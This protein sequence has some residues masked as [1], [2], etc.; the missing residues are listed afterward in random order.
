MAIVDVVEK[1]KRVYVYDKN[2]DVLFTFVINPKI[3]D[4]VVDYS[5]KFVRVK[6]GDT[7]RIYDHEGEFVSSSSVK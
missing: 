6:R 3:G 7:I 2:R 4:T 5:S 1:G